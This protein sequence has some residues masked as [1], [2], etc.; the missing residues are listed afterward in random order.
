MCGYK[1]V[2]QWLNDEAHCLK[3][4]TVLKRRP[5]V[6]QRGGTATGPVSSTQQRASSQP[7]MYDNCSSLRTSDDPRVSTPAKLLGSSPSRQLVGPERFFYD[8]STFTGTHAQGSHEHSDK[9]GAYHLT[10]LS[11]LSSSNNRPNGKVTKAGARNDEGVRMECPDC[12]YKF[13]PQWLNGE[14]HC[15]KCQAVRFNSYMKDQVS[16]VHEKSRQ[17]RASTPGKLGETSSP[18]PASWSGQRRAST[19]ARL[20]ENSSSKRMV[21]PER[22]FYDKSTYTGAHAHGGHK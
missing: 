22:F 12:G 20:E 11:S 7:K 9:H 10:L 19:P 3:C 1:C 14:A 16:G 18:R 5:S 4:Q 2:P 17:R 15:L 13:V 8:T 21:G 6:H